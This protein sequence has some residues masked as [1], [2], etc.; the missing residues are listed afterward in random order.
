M[1]DTSQLTTEKQQTNLRILQESVSAA[2][3]SQEIPTVDELLAVRM[4]D[5]IELLGYMSGKHFS[6]LPFSDPK[7]A[8]QSPF[9]Y[10]SDK[11]SA[12]YIAG[13][14]LEILRRALMAKTNEWLGMDLPVIV[15]LEWL[16][17][18]KPGTISAFS[19]AQRTC[20][21]RCL[22][23]V[24]K[25]P[26]FFFWEDRIGELESAIAKVAPTP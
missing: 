24:R 20:I 4:P 26:E 18:M 10:L 21:Y 11:A 7:F 12:Y 6:G 5:S 25:Y 19:I 8:H 16:M 1:P 23:L 2:W 17:K 15:T 3:D 14:L 13:Y 9:S 22:D